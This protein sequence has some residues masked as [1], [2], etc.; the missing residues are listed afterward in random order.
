MSTA[1][2]SA[3]HSRGSESRRHSWFE[4]CR[5]LP[6]GPNLFDGLKPFHRP[7]MRSAG[8]VNLM[9]QWRQASTGLQR[10]PRVATSVPV[11]ISTV[12]PEVDPNTGKLFFRSAEETTANLSRGGA[13]LRSWEPL[14]PGRRVVVAIDLASGRELQLTGRVVWTRRELRPVQIRNVEAPGYGIEFL[15]SSRRELD[16][17]DQLIENLDQPSRVTAQPS[18]PA[19]TPA[20]PATQ[21]TVPAAT[22]ARAPA[23]AATTRH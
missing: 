6:F 1:K 14:E 17:L 4:Y 7:P 12:D 13:Y 23:S 2:A 18:G 15:G 22:S 16:R 21:A 8:G 11:R 5:S 20:T 19:T 9:G 10:H 3:S